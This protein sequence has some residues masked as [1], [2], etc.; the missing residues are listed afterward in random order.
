M[1]DCKECAC[2]S[3]MSHHNWMSHDEYRIVRG[4]M[5]FFLVLFVFIAG[6]ALG[7]LKAYLRQ[8]DGYGIKWGRMSPR[9]MMQPGQNNMMYDTD[10]NPFTAPETQ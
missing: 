3:A 2:S 10:N 7:E 9:S 1:D 4:I 6:L 5:M 8:Q